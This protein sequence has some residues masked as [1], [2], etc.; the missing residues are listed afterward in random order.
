GATRCSLAAP[1][2]AAA[3]AISAAAV[4]A[5]PAVVTATNVHRLRRAAARIAGVLL[6]VGAD[7]ARVVVA[8]LLGLPLRVGDGAS[9]RLRPA[10]LDV[11]AEGETVE[12]HPSGHML[13]RIELDHL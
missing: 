12:V 3:A 11:V 2:S 13:Q 4:T 10:I 5:A 9:V 6:T 7:E 1:V 8:V